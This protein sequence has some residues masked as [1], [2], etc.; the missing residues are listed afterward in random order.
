MKKLNIGI[1]ADQFINWGGGIDFIRLIL[2]GLN[3][4]NETDEYEIDIFVYVPIQSEFKIQIKNLIKNVLNAILFQK[5]HIQKISVEKKLI[6]ESFK[7]INQNINIIYYNGSE[8]DLSKKVLIDNID[9]VLPAFK[10]LSSKFPKPWAGYIYDFQHKYYPEF[11][12][13]EEIR[14]RDESFSVM[15]KDAEKV[16]VNAKAVKNDIE[17]YIDI[18]NAKVINLPFC[19]VLNMDFFEDLDLSDL[20]IPENYFMISNQFWKHKDHITAFKAFKTFVDTTADSQIGLV[21]T[22]LTKDYRFPSYFFELEELINNLNLKGR[23]FILGYIPK[24]QQLQILKKAI[25][26]IQPTLFE[27]GPGGG[28]VYESVAYGIPS[29]VSDIPV[30][31]ELIDESV[32]FF[33]AG[34]SDD[35]MDKMKIVYN[36]PR[37]NFTFDELLVKNE[38]R[39]LAMGK[40]IIHTIID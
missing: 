2:N 27:G 23:V 6:V 25:A 28:A 8:K 12:T 11:F 32:T 36:N 13:D 39:M 1:L 14:L 40:Q 24:K 22:G 19:P 4:F 16:I 5:F 18:K 9:F 3:S 38:K 30:N 29:I 10:P 31:L 20:S 37:V 35:L 34:S 26:V 15:M 21:C 33:N 17:K 7:N